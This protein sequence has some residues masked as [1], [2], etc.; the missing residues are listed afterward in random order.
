[1]ENFNVENFESE[2]SLEKK[3]LIL[4]SLNQ[5]QSIAP[6]VWQ[7]DSG[8]EG[9][10]VMF[11]EATH[12]NETENLSI[13]LSI[14]E[15]VRN[16]ALETGVLTL[17][18]GNPIAF[19]LDKRFKDFDLNRSFG[20]YNDFNH[21]E[22]LRAEELKPIL[23]ESDLLLD[24]HATIK[25]SK[26]FLVLPELNHPL[27]E[28][29]LPSL[30]IKTVLT[31][32]GIFAAGGQP[33]YTDTYVCQ[34]GGFGVTIEAGWLEEMETETICEAIKKTLVKVGIFKETS[35]NHSMKL[36]DLQFWDAYWNVVAG[37]EF[38]FTKEWSNFDVLE[39]GVTFAI[40]GSEALIANEKSIIVFPKSKENIVV[41]TEACII[42]KSL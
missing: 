13:L 21:Y 7:F 19:L 42:A 8:K 25:P 39:E 6:Y 40:N 28:L 14:I 30:G 38:H 23:A 35:T 29:V 1:M 12:G 16:G 11:M 26:P 24:L 32:S 2:N 31:G 22:S 37:E 18:I 20:D 17:A 10:S 36:K 34:N 15:E 27:S 3:L 9:P 4:K 5:M 41:G 33:I